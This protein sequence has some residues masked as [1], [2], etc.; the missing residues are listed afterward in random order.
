MGEEDKALDWAQ[1]AIEQRH[2]LI[3]VFLAFPI[4]KDFAVHFTMARTI[5]VDEPAGGGSM[6]P[7]QNCI[8]RGP[9]T[10]TTSPCCAK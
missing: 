4:G 2:P 10:R 1:K 6:T 3:L 7:K 9:S 8:Q 5:E